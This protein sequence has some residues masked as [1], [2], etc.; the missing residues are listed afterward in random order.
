MELVQ[1]CDLELR[2]TSLDLVDYGA[3]GQIYGTMDGWFSGD[4]LSGTVR[5]TNLAQRRPD[6]V[7]V[8]TLRGLVETPDGARLYIEVNGLAQ[9]RPRDQ[10]RVFVA[11]VTFRT[12]HESYV[13]LNRAFCVL[14]GVLDTVAVGGLARGR[15]YECQATYA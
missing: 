12:A 14:E 13:W 11:S 6:D 7:N 4:R 15:V 10:A 9:L 1:V 3:G 2:Y 8:P 5:L